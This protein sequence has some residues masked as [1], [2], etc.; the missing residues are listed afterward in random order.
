MRFAEC[1]SGAVHKFV[2]AARVSS[3]HWIREETTEPKG[4]L[5]ALLSQPF[6]FLCSGWSPLAC[7]ASRFGEL[8]NRFSTRIGSLP[9]LKAHAAFRGNNFP[10]NGYARDAHEQSMRFWSAANPCFSQLASGSR[11]PQY[12]SFPCRRSHT[13]S[14]CPPD[15]PWP[16][17]APSAA[18]GDDSLGSE[19]R[20]VLLYG[21][22][23][24]QPLVP[25]SFAQ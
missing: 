13:H 1:R 3:G 25:S 10:S 19:P 24:H 14:G 11:R 4:A 21:P 18:S 8:R 22:A 7:S 17:C 5:L 9:D 15:A 2:I 16:R 12:V 20:A 6:G 23:S